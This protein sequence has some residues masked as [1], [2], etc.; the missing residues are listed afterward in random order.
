M[1]P[2]LLRPQINYPSMLRKILQNPEKLEKLIKRSTKDVLFTYN[3]SLLDELKQLSDQEL[4]SYF[5]NVNVAYLADN[6]SFSNEMLPL[7]KAIINRTFNLKI[8]LLSQALENTD[9]KEFVNQTAKLRLS[10]I[11]GSEYWKVQRV[12]LKTFA[13]KLLEQTSTQLSKELRETNVN[14]LLA[15][16]KTIEI[17][18]VEPLLRRISKLRDGELV[19]AVQNTDLAAIDNEQKVSN[20]RIAKNLTELSSSDFAVTLQATNIDKYLQK[21]RS[22]GEPELA[23]AMA[24]KLLDLGSFDLGVA[25]STTN[26]VELYKILNRINQKFGEKSIQN[27]LELK[28]KDFFKTACHTQFDSFADIVST[29]TLIEIGKKLT[30]LD[31]AKSVRAF[32][33]TKLE[34]FINAII[35]G[36]R[37][38]DNVA[39]DLLIKMAL[40]EAS[41]YL[42]ATKNS[43]TKHLGKIATGLGLFKAAAVH[44]SA[45]EDMMERSSRTLKEFDDTQG[46]LLRSIRGLEANKPVGTV[47]RTL[48]IDTLHIPF[49]TGGPHAR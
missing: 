36:D 38:M 24:T 47:L 7:A 11:A 2:T 43:D 19:D 46:I 1:I 26:Y 6:L 14:E 28:T 32:E 8:E 3:E 34:V 37:S 9:L 13:D 45:D 5:Q 49:F 39:K 48:G 27:L 40:I 23:N 33:F 15:Y 16:F 10:D 41:S 25:A 22:Y 20:I 31:P 44:N 12:L 18:I 42:V 4:A 21:L 35:T 29:D 17:D 30:E